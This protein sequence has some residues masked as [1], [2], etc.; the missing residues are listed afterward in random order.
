M[1]RYDTVFRARRV[2]TAA[3]ETGGCVGVAHGR[4]AAICRR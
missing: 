4:I 2:V 3:G 1:S